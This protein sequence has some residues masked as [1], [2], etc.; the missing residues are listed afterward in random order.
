MTTLYLVRHG[1]SEGNVGRVLQ[2]QTHGKLTPLGCRQVI[3]AARQ[4]A[5]IRIDLFLSSDLRRAVQTCR[6]LISHLGCGNMLTTPLLRERDW[7][8]FTGRLI[9]DI[10]SLQL[11]D[12]VE[13]LPELKDRAREFLRMVRSRYDGQTIVVVSHG[14]M[15]K[16]IQAVALRKPMHEVQ[17]MHN[18]EIRVLPLGE[19]SRQ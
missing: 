18:A 15:L 5:D 11:P 3:A 1:E 2:G 14:I 10:E 6:L 8:D 9:P 4:L 13:T 19:H 16:A 7:G 12:N 17:K